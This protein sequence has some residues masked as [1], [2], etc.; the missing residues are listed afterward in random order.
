L[1]RYGQLPLGFEPNQGQTDPSVRF[2]AHRG[3]YALFL[4]PVEMTFSL[5]PA[6]GDAPPSSP[7]GAEATGAPAPYT[8]S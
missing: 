3:G 2:L 6:G 4:S 1:A 8:S 5:Q 7:E